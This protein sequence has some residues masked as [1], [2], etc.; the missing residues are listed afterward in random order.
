MSTTMSEKRQEDHLE[1]TSSTSHHHHDDAHINEKNLDNRDPEKIIERDLSSEDLHQE[2][3]L[4]TK[5][6]AA[7]L[8]LTALLYLSAYLDRGN[9]GNAR[10][11]GLQANLLGGSDNKYSV[12]LTMFFGELNSR[13]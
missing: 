1:R 5:L 9:I 3:R 12:V 11:Q 8:P 4:L 2:R 7:I 10:L 6:D 13:G